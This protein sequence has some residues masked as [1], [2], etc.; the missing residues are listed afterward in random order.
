MLESARFSGPLPSVRDPYG[1]RTERDGQPAEA[2]LAC[3]A[4]VVRDRDN[5]EHRRRLQDLIAGVLRPEGS[6]QPGHSVVFLGQAYYHFYYLAAALRRRGWDAVLV[7]FEDP[8]GPNAPFYHGD[9]LNFYSP[10]VAVMAQIMRA[11]TEQIGRRFSVVHSMGLTVTAYH[12]NGLL[13]VDHD[14]LVDLARQRNASVVWSPSG[15]LEGIRQS[16]F[17]AWSGGACDRCVWQ[18]EPFRCS[19]DANI[20][21]TRPYAGT[22]VIDVGCDAALDLFA[23]DNAFHEPLSY[24]L[25]PD[26]WNPDLAIPDDLAVQRRPGEILVYHAV[27]NA[28]IRAQKGRNIKG[29]PAVLAAVDRLRGEGLDISLI[30]VPLNTPNLRVRHLMVQADIVVDQ[31]NYGRWGAT[32]RE[33]LMLGK[34]VVCNINTNNGSNSPSQAL[35]DHPL[36]HATEDTVCAV[37]RNLACNPAARAK[38][39]AAGRAYA[40]RWYASD[41]C[42]ARYEALLDH[43]AAGGAVRTAPLTPVG[44]AP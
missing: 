42:A 2:I 43:V 38:A 16:V 35:S 28:H 29:T 37:L 15:C 44:G 27:G 7:S 6:V 23:T 1:T 13:D 12:G 9:D 3:A 39:G 24:C 33:A 17:N 18:T 11:I 22:M 36:I 31:L 34:P 4:A 41:A 32:A 20:A 40:L 8:Q 19:D 25:D 21:R 30:P 10:S 5:L 14:G 26:V